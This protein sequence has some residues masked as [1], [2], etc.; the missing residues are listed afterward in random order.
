MTRENLLTGNKPRLEYM[1]AAKAL[2]IVTVMLGH[3]VEYVST[4]TTT[5]RSGHSSILSTC[6]CS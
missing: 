4:W 2:A 1:D 6:R 5:I 3:A